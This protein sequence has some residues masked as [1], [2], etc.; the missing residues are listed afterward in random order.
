MA[1]KTSKPES[2]SPDVETLASL[3]E[4]LAR[5][6]TKGNLKE[7]LARR[8]RPKESA[9]EFT[10]RIDATLDSI[11]AEANSPGRGSP[12]FIVRYPDEAMRAKIARLAKKNNR[13][14]NAEI[15]DR[16]Q[17]SMIDD[18]INNL[19]ESMAEIFD[20]VE[21][22]ESLIGDHQAQLNNRDDPSNE[23]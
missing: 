14:I 17:K 6:R 1:K 21:K 16:L 15:I 7:L 8:P 13:S 4:R 19:E 12:Q 10:A 2:K 18:A 23:D 9:E 3:K 22:L 11:R 5:S 20:R